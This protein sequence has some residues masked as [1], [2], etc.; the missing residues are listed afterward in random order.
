MTEHD[1][2]Y[3]FGKPK[4]YLSDKEKLKLR[5]HTNPRD[6]EKRRGQEH[7]GK[8]D[9]QKAADRIQEEL[10]RRRGQQKP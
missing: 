3:Q 5:T 6:V 2:P 9:V 7:S 10:R 8:T 1:E 4:E